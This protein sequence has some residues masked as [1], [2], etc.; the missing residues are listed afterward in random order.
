MANQY[1]ELAHLVQ[2]NKAQCTLF[3]VWRHLQIDCRGALT[4]I[5]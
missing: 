1:Y 5:I 2:I 3:L 4:L